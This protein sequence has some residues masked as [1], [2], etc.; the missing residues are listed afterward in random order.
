M[1][2]FEPMAA[3]SWAALL[4]VIVRFFAAADAVSTIIT[5]SATTTASVFPRAGPVV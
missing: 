4:T 3:T 2:R 5:A 1:V